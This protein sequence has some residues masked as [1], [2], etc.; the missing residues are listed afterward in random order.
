M[1]SMP[2]LPVLAL[3]TATLSLTTALAGCSSNKEPVGYDQDR[4][5]RLTILHTN[6][7]RGQFWRNEKGE[8][9]MAAR[10]T[11][12]DSVRD[13]VEAEGGKVLVLSAGDINTGVPESDLQDAKP[14]LLG[15]NLIGYDAMTVGNHEFDNPLST[16]KQQE[17][18]AD[19]PFL[20]AN[21]YDAETGRPLFDA[22]KLFDF[23]SLS[24]AVF[25]LTSEDTRKTGNPRFVADVDFRDPVT[26]ASRLVPLMKDQADIVIGL[27]HLGHY[28]YGL[29]GENS[30]G[31]ITLSRQISGI[32]VIIGGHSESP[33]YTP[34]KQGNT[35]IMQAADK[36][37]YVG[38]A[39]FVFQNGKLKLENY[40]LIPVNHQQQ[41]NKV[42]EDPEML[43]LL[44]PYQEEGQRRIL[45][46]IGQTH[47]RLQGEPSE[48]R[49]R[50]TNLG[51]M[52]ATAQMRVTRADFAVVNSGSIRASIPAGNISYK[53]VLT[54]QPYGNS[55]AYL[56]LTGR[57]IK[58]YLKV[59]ALKSA[60]TPAFPQF[61]G[62]EMIIKRNKVKSIRIQGRPLDN[63]KSY[64]MAINSFIAEGGDGYPKLSN[65]PSYH[66]TDLTDADVLREYIQESTPLQAARY[67]PIGIFRY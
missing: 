21:T 35:Y 4:A 54:T 48:V 37:K 51:V 56:T 65:H 10:K 46:T 50:S 49:N 61:A 20:S 64:R 14:D 42:P 66:S 19:F 22:Y 18:Q 15:M 41:L 52:I 60:N 34:D 26:V 40:E 7:N 12:I 36:G 23:G 32:D 53:D 39:D 59:V 16:L 2:R 8:W 13:E 47:V 27:T 25:G 33:L 9:G 3:L 44:S 38:R 24:I 43:S 55:V 57:E 45:E 6:D 62:V 29:H 11:I 67:E 5:Y 28:K 1:H 17:D 30:P 31:D 63:S 58:E